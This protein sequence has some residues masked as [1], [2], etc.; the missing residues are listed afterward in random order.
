MSTISHNTMTDA[1]EMACDLEAIGDAILTPGDPSPLGRTRDGDLAYPVFTDHAYIRLKRRDIAI[2]ALTLARSLGITEMP[3]PPITH[4]TME[5]LLHELVGEALPVVFYEETRHGELA[6]EAD[7]RHL[8][9]GE[10][11]RISRLWE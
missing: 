9:A 6:R 8:L 1:G 3:Q 2:L 4:G 7:I 5:A 11:E 10:I